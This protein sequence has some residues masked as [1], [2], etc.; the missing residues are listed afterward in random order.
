MIKEGV[1]LAVEETNLSNITQS[2]HALI[3]DIPYTEYNINI[4]R[5]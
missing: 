2:A 4:Y 5:A 3:K 1:K